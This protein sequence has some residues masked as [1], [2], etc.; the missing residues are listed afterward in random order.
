MIGN[1]PTYIAVIFGFT[2]IATLIFF[3]TVVKNSSSEIIRKKSGVL[4][5][6]LT[7]WLI[8]QA[9]LTLNNVYSA[10]TNALPPKIMLF[11]IFPPLIIL[12]LLFSTKKGK[13]FIDSLPLKNI[14]YLNVVRIPVELV[15][16]FLFL[17]NAVPE[18]MTFE[19]RNFDIIAGITAPIIA[20]FYFT[21]H[22]IN[23]KL[24]LIWNFICLGLLINII[25]NAFLAAPT[26]FQ[27]FA[28]DQ[29]NIA[30][31]NFP[32]S[33]LPIFIVPIV[34][35]GHLVSIRQLLGKLSVSKK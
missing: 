23:S 11:G 28:F 17:N 16:Y 15:L 21:K 18:L 32:F 9:V 26:P 8:V 20:Y 1:L 33:F 4:F 7:A 29:P 13:Y 10:K 3:I 5:I 24:L 27:K 2:T 22:I 31:I 34:L 30:I 25:V 14:T 35:L 12:V 6:T 19:G